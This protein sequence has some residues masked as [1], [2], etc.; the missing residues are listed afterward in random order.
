MLFECY[1]HPLFVVIQE[2]YAPLVIV[3]DGGFS[4]FR[5]QL[6]DDQV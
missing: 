5:K 3:A 2:L 6:H 4:K 1:F